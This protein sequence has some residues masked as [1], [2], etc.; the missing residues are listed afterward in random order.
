MQLSTILAGKGGFVATVQPDATVAELVSLLAEHRVGALV[1]SA[2]GRTIRLTG[3]SVSEA[4]PNLWET[5]VGRPHRRSRG[6]VLPGPR[7]SP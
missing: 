5:R 7:Q 6:G 2:D 4:R 3:Q 1:V